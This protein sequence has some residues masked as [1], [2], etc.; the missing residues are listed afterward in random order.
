MKQIFSSRSIS[1][2]KLT[3]L[4]MML[5]ATGV[6]LSSYKLAAKTADDLWK[7]LG[8]SQQQGSEKIKSSF[9]SGYL[10]Y[11]GARNIRNISSGN[12][13]MVAKDLLVYTKNYLNSDAVKNAYAKERESV[14][15]TPPAAANTVTREDIRKEQIEGM[16]KAIANTEAMIKQF[17]DMEK[18]ARKS[19]LEFEKMIK[20]FEKPDSELI[21]IL[22]QGKLAEN[23]NNE[24][25][26][27]ESLRSWEKNFPADYRSKLRSYL[28]KYL[29]IASTV[30]FN[31]ELTEKYNKKVFVK[32]AYES[33][34]DEW[35]MI[36]RAGK[37]VY[38]VAK[39][40]AEQWLKELSAN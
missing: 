24:D 23:K 17:P 28:E 7:Q 38:E 25:R 32:S 37:E 19:L 27:N 15:P 39:P 20:D 36:F 29:S 4:C 40:F 35:K 21:N 5:L 10:D 11:W 30:D 1:M 3:G 12:K 13:A 18:S 2:L 34:D 6:S 33:K 16:K 9:I 31:A 26:Y 8:I 14:K 22:Y